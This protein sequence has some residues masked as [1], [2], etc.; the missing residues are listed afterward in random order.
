MVPP[1]LATANRRCIV[2]NTASFGIFYHA[3]M[4]TSLEI[5]DKEVI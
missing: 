4:W 1:G 3:L 5:G 2:D